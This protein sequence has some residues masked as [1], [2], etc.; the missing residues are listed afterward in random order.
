MNEGDY[1]AL[2]LYWQNRLTDRDRLIR[3]QCGRWN[4]LKHLGVTCEHCGTEVRACRPAVWLRL[5]RSRLRWLYW[6]RARVFG[7]VVPWFDEL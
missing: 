2:I 7:G 3:C 1:S 5:A 6:A 4:R